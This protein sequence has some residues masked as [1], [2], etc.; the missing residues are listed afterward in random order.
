MMTASVLSY[1]NSHD[2]GYRCK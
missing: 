2:I 1:L